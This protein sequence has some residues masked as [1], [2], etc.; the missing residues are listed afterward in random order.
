[1]AMD[2]LAKSIVDMSRRP[3]D[4][5]YYILNTLDAGTL[6]QLEVE[7]L[8]GASG[9]KLRVR[10]LLPLRAQPLLPPGGA[11]AAESTIEH[12]R[13]NIVLGAELSEA[14]VKT[15]VENIRSTWL[16]GA[17]CGLRRSPIQA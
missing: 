8:R 9:G 1:M 15:L 13:S 7:V 12:R 6:L 5:T 3:G 16:T 14:G 2:D 17:R 10:P 4:G 11:S